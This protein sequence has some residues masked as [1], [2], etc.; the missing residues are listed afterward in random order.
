MIHYEDIR[1]VDEKPLPIEALREAVLNAVT[2]KSYG[3]YT[4]VQIRVFDDRI[5]IW[6]P[7]YLPSGWDVS[8]LTANHGSKPF[9]PDIA[10][11]FFRAGYVESWGRGIEKIISSCKTYGCPNPEWE[12]DGA[13]ICTKLMYKKGNTSPDLNHQ[14]Q[15]T[16]NNAHDDAHEMNTDIQRFNDYLI[17]KF[18]LHAQKMRMLLRMMAHD[19]NREMGLSSMMEIVE[20]EQRRTFQRNLL[21]PAMEEGLLEHTIPDK[22]KS[23]YQKYRI[24]EKA[25]RLIE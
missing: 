20:I 23:R 5:E 8:R 7:G 13:G 24:T 9:N 6:N 2:H 15:N 18:G 25:R 21:Y 14:R 12:Y 3:D 16:D 17:D 10:N 11:V 19:E 4:P 22:P 1:R